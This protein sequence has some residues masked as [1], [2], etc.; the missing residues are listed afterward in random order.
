MIGPIRE[1]GKQTCTDASTFL[2]LHAT[3]RKTLQ[4]IHCA[5]VACRKSVQARKV[6]AWSGSSYFH[7]ACFF[8]QIKMQGKK[9]AAKL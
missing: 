7:F 5:G 4:K 9:G 8:L 6:V 1:L 3:G 2:L